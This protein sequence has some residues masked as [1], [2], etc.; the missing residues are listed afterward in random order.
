MYRIQNEEIRKGLVI[1]NFLNKFRQFF[2]QWLGQEWTSLKSG[3][4]EIESV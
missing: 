1:I 4:L 2:L 3:N